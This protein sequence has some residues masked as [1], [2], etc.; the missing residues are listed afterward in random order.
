VA[1]MTVY[2]VGED[3][4]RWLVV[5]QHDQIHETL[6]VDEARLAVINTLREQLLPG[7]AESFT[8]AVVT[9]LDAP[10][11]VV[12]DA[13]FADAETE[14]VCFRSPIGSTRPRGQ[15]IGTCAVTFGF[16]MVDQ[17]YR[18]EADR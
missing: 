4:D 17:Y 13:V 5:G 7:E 11:Y 18:P 12:I 15:K 10:A 16:R 14:Q 2:D 9:A 6:G 8:E 3:S 1:E